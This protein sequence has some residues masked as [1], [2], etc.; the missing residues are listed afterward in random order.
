LGGIVI[1]SPEMVFR[2]AFLMNSTDTAATDMADAMI[3]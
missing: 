2:P 3:S 1:G